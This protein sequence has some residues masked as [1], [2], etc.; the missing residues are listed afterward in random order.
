MASSCSDEPDQRALLRLRAGWVVAVWLPQRSA[1]RVYFH[2]QMGGALVRACRQ[3]GGQW[4]V[5]GA[6]TRCVDGLRA[7]WP[8]ECA[9]P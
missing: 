1:E 6:Q 2:V 7:A 5:A 8:D 9:R 3:V 4:A